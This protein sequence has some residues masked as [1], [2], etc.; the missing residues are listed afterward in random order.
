MKKI[1]LMLLGIAWFGVLV[2]EA[3]V[4]SITGNVT[5]SDD[6]MG[7]PGVS[8]SVKGTTIGTV[9]NLDGF[10]QLEVPADAATL[11]FSFVGMKT[12]E[13][14]ISGSVINATL[15]P[16]VIGVD[17]VMVV[18]Y[19]TSTKGSFTGSAGVVEAKEIEKRQVSNISNALAG[20]IAG[21]QVLS[22][23]GQPGSSATIRVRGVGSINAETDPLYVVDGV[24]F[25]GDL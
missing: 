12:Q 13:K 3:Q 22:N 2:A 5:S 14:P 25:D 7:I 17:E 18:A 23:N 6:D 19:G 15:V 10:Y 1:A 4:K 16:D 21:V 9:T 24:P 11:V 8:V 20:T